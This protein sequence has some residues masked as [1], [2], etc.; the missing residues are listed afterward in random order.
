MSSRG[1]AE[2]GVLLCAR[3]HGEKRAPTTVGEGG[4]RRRGRCCSALG[5]MLYAYALLGALSSRWQDAVGGAYLEFHASLLSLFSQERGHGRRRGAGDLVRGTQTSRASGARVAQRTR[6]A[7]VLSAPVE[8]ATE[9]TAGAVC[10]VIAAGLIAFDSRAAGRLR[11]DCSLVRGA[12]LLV[13][14]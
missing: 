3:L 6:R 14:R 7:A 2:T 11:R 4:L 10:L 9:N 1:R 5:G 8:S 12:M 13:K